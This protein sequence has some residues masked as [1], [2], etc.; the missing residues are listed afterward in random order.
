MNGEIT[1]EF[2]KKLRA[3]NKRMQT[4][5]KFALEELE[6]TGHGKNEWTY[7]L[8]EKIKTVLKSK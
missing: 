2:V 4:V 8:A 3:D 6:R 7:R 1:E 5:L